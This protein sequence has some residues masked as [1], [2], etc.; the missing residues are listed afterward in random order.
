MKEN[1][2]HLKYYWTRNA[3]DKTRLLIFLLWKLR[4]ARLS[5]NAGITYEQTERYGYRMAVRKI[6]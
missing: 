2:T 6:F 5:A 4:L 3:Q 1:I